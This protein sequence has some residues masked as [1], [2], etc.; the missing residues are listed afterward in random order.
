MTT[1]AQKEHMAKFYQSEVERLVTLAQRDGVV[2]TVTQ[3]PA[4]K[5]AMGSYHTLVE[6]RATRALP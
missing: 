2:V 6:T 1:Q 5:L 4:A 3:I